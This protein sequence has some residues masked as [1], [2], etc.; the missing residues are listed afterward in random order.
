MIRIKLLVFG[1]ISAIALVAF[2]VAIGQAPLP[3]LSKTQV[4]ISQEIPIVAN[5]LVPIEGG[6]SITA[7]VPLTMSIDMVV[8][9]SGDTVVKVEPVAAPAPTPI[10]KVSDAKSVPGM[11]GVDSMGIPYVLKAPEGLQLDEWTVK[12][13][14]DGGIDYKF[15]VSTPGK[16]FNSDMQVDVS[17][18]DDS[19]T[20]IAKSGVIIF[21]SKSGQDREKRSY[22]NSFDC[23]WSECAE[24]PVNAKSYTITFDVEVVDFP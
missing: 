23:S 21:G 6:E 8:T 2:G 18:L 4:Q 14:D 17:Y 1:F 16:K 11:T 13:K 12:L 20:E 19:G 7:S 10:I 24:V 9:L 3:L 22:S 15:K 5:I